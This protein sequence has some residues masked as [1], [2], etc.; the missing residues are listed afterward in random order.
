MARLALTVSV[1]H[2]RSSGMASLSVDQVDR[3]CGR[4]RRSTA[5]RDSSPAVLCRVA[6]G[7]HNTALLRMRS[8]LRGCTGQRL[9][10][11][12]PQA[13]VE[14]LVPAAQPAICRL[15][16]WIVQIEAAVLEVQTCPRSLGLHAVGH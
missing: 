2:P 1:L 11:N 8:R 9:F 16:Q 10:D 13:C 7:R 15:L 14:L 3:Q 12:A 5:V 6:H 4:D